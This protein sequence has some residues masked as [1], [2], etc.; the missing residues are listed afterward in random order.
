MK[1]CIIALGMLMH[2]NSLAR[3]HRLIHDIKIE[4][5]KITYFLNKK[6]HAK[7][8]RENLYVEYENDI[9]LSQLDYTILT[10]PLIMNTIGIIW[11]SNKEYSIPVM[12][13]E[14]YYSLKTVKEVF[15][16][17][18]PYTRFD[19]ELI[20]K[21]LVNNSSFWHTHAWQ[22]GVALPF[23]HGLDS[24]CTSMRHRTT[25]QLLITARGMPDTPLEMWQENWEYTQQVIEKYA[26]IHGHTTAYISSNFHE[27]FNWKELCAF[28]P[29]I[30]HWR[31]CMVKGLGWM[32]L[33]APILI[34]KGH[35]TFMLPANGDWGS[36]HPGA[37]CPLINDVVHFAG[38]TNISDGFEI[39]RALKN[40]IIA[41]ICTSHHLEKPYFII[42]ENVLP[43][44]EN[45]CTCYKCSTSIIA[46]LLIDEDP[47]D[48]GFPIALTSFIDYFKNNFIEK[49]ELEPD[50]ARWFKYYQ[51]EAIKK[52]STFTPELQNFFRWYIKLNF[53]TSVVE[54]NNI[55][56][57]Y[58]KFTDLY[59]HIP[60]EL[61]TKDSL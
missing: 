49:A 29:E 33:A 34:S 30:Q 39:T 45:C 24:L 41:D 13:E 52:M 17:F 15:K 56:I 40:Q 18:Y 27:F 36:P 22:D 9:E 20:P 46:L 25:P 7:Y 60:P 8:L 47:R 50:T 4:N 16:R 10:M 14:L 61:I 57:D 37:D 21:K 3:E 32:G 44:R 11:I 5:Q 59:A 38:I 35:R 53:D 31:L 55:L 1:K 43:K 54:W 26:Q 12:D 28:S 58:S 6:F 19:G 51:D 42:C 48:Y 2:L 23:S